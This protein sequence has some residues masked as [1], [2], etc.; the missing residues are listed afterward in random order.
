MR[1]FF[2]VAIGSL[3]EIDSMVA[4][5]GD[6]YDLDSRVLADVLALRARTSKRLFSLMRA[7]GR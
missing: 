7:R 3:A 5:R 2:D 1:R 6:L 4:T